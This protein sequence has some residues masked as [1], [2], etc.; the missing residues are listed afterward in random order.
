MQLAVVVGSVTA[1]VKDAGLA[2]RKLSLV[3]VVGPDGSPGPDLEVALDVTSAG[4]GEQ[5]LLVR[6]S[7]ARQPAPNRSLA[8]DLSIVAIVDEV[9]LSPE[10]N[11]RK[12]SHG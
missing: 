8:A 2:G 10:K 6:G 12:V 9:Y 7:A 1:T 3:R 4:V 5:V 11:P